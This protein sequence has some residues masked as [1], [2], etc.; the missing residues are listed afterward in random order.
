MFSIAS[1][2]LTNLSVINKY[3]FVTKTISKFGKSRGVVFFN[4]VLMNLAGLKMGDQMDIR[5][6]PESGAIVLTPLRKRPSK[7]GNQFSH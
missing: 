5:V 4:D 2:V 3:Y 6:V 1:R 7:K